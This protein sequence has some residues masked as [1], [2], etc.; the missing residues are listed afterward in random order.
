MNRVIFCD[1]TK[2]D[3]EIRYRQGENSIAIDSFSI[4]IDSG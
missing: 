2:K 3:V 1:K 4:V